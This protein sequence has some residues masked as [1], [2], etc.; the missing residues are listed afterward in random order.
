MDR[1]PALL[2]RPTAL[3]RPIN[4]SRCPLRVEGQER[5]K[6]GREGEQELSE[7]G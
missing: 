1:W 3:S 7:T 2:A 5:V 6:E 4:L